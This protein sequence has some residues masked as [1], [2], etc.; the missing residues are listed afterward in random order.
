MP[1]LIIIAT[2]VVY[3]LLPDAE[4]HAWGPGVHMAAG[5]WVLANLDCIAPEVGRLLAQNPGSFLYGSLAADIFIGKGS[6]FRPGHSHNWSTGRLLLANATSDRTRAYAYGYLSHLAADTVAHNHYVPGMMLTLAGGGRMGHV[7]VEMQADR[8]VRWDSDQA[9]R[10]FTCPQQD[11]DATLLATVRER[12]LPFLLKKQMMKGHLHLCRKRTWARSLDAAD[13]VT[14]LGHQAFFREMFTLTLD[15]V[16]DFLAA[17]EASG[18]RELDPIGS[19]P[20][21]RVKRTLRKQRRKA[22]IDHRRAPGAQFPL[23]RQ[24]TSLPR[25]HCREGKTQVPLRKAG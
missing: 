19:R 25:A 21:W 13:R 20:L 5:N 4:A 23:P 12:R 11:T 17:P 10:L 2:C 18:V 22:R 6:T 9:F 16:C 15:A 24:L 8:M 1:F 3:L 7:Y 14:R